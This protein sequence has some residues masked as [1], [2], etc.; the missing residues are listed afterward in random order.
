MSSAPRPIACPPTRSHGGWAERATDIHRSTVFRT[1]KRL[2]S[3]GVLDHIHLPHGATTYHVHDS[4]RTH[5]HLACRWCGTVVDIDARSL[6]EVA[7]GVRDKW[8]FELE[9]AHSALSGA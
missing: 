1:L 6:D 9:P 3:L 4:Q 7:A 5:L 8:G 2:V